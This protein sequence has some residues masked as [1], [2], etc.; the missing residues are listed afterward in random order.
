MLVDEML[1]LLERDLVPPTTEADT[2]GAVRIGG[3]SV[4]GVSTTRRIRG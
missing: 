2:D 1:C 4:F 3:V